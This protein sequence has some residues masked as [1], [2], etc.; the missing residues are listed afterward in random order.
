MDL[1]FRLQCNN[2]EY[3]FQIFPHT[4]AH[5]SR[6]LLNMRILTTKLTVYWLTTKLE[7]KY[8]IMCI[9]VCFY[10]DCNVTELGGT[11]QGG[12]VDSRC[13]NRTFMNSLS[14]SGGVI[15]Y[16]G[17]TLGSRAVYICS[18]NY[19]LR[20]MEGNEITRV[21]Q[22][23]GSWNGTIPQCRLGKLLHIM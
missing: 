17:T 12:T 13:A 15:C 18:D 6:Y 22:S 23:N 10:L 20:M 5:T 19:T 1:T 8:I 16:D 3:H 11:T 2:V 21:C 7:Y 14:I 4:L 9:L